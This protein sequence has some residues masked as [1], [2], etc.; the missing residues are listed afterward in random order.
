MSHWIVPVFLTGVCLYGLIRRVDVFGLFL[1]GAA[2]GLKSA[3]AILPPLIAVMTGVAMCRASGVLELLS[4]LAAPV[5]QWIGFP[6]EALPLALLRPVSG[7]G[8]LGMLESLL[9]A[10]GADSRI[11]RV[12]SVLQG[13]TETTFYA[14]AVYYSGR[15]YRSLRYTIPAALCGDCCAAVLSVLAV[16]LFFG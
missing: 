2:E 10:Y 1:E 9:G 5:L 13:S 12:A 7:S 14:A 8:A 3:A 11:G 15:G 6:A 4:H 16:R